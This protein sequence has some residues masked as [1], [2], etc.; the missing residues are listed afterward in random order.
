MR[1]VHGNILKTPKGAS[2]AVNPV[3]LEVLSLNFTLL[4]FVPI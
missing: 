2:K 4:I 1:E 3:A